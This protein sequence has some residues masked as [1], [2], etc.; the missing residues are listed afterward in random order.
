MVPHDRNVDLHMHSSASDGVLSPRDLVARGVANGLEVMALTD[1]DTL[2]G[3]SEAAEAASDLGIRFVPGVE[4]S[5]TWAGET[6]HVL[7][8]GVNPKAPS[9]AGAL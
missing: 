1:H 8:L 4:V 3:L 9:L 2:D 7:G 5:V 6:L